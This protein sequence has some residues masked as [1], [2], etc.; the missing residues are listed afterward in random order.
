MART[1]EWSGRDCAVMRF[2]AVGV[3]VAGYFTEVYV[4][5]DLARRPIVDSAARRRWWGR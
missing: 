4:N 2:D 5:G 3:G 1:R